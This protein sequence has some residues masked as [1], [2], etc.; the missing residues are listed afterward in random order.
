MNDMYQKITDLVSKS[1]SFVY[2]EKQDQWISFIVS[3]VFNNDHEGENVVLAMEGLEHG[4]VASEVLDILYSTRLETDSI[5]HMIDMIMFY[6]KEGPKFIRDI[7]PNLLTDDLELKVQKM[8]EE[9][10]AYQ[11][12]GMIS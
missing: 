1:D 8:E 7:Y 5:Q 4:M 12:K 9:N 2:K 6:Y 10:R 11:K 3:S